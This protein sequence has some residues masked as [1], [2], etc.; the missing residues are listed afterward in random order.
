VN[1]TGGRLLQGDPKTSF[2]G[3][4]TDTRTIKRGE[5]FLALKG[6]HF[7]GHA[8]VHEAVKK[9]AAGAIVQN[10]DLSQ[11]VT[12]TP[13]SVPLIAV[14]ETLRALG[15]TARYWRDRF[16]IPLI[17]ITGSNGKTSTKELIA[18]FL[19]ERSRVLKSPGNYNN[20][21]GLPLTLLGLEPV[22]DVAIVEMGTNRPGE[23]RRLS[24]IAHPTVGI[25]TNIGQAHLEGMGTMDTLIREKGALFRAVEPGGILVVN[26]ND[27]HVS[28][29]AHG[30]M[31]KVIH[32]GVNTDADVVISHVR[33][34]GSQGYSF[35]LS[36]G[37]EE[38]LIDLP[39]VG[40]QFVDN[41]AAAAAVASL[42]EI[43]V[44]YIQSRL[45][46]FIP[47]PMRMEIISIRGANFINDAYNANP[48]SVKKALETL[49]HVEPEGRTFVV[50]GDML[51]LGESSR[52]AHRSVGELMGT[53]NLAGSFLLGHRVTDVAQ[54]A[55]ERGMSRDRIWI[56]R[57]H[58]DIANLLRAHIKA[59]DWILVK[60]SR[61]M[62]MEAVINIFREDV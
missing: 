57:N 2:S 7:D 58:R 29:L 51:E 30:S 18:F 11:A 52:K 35:R 41:V 21:I 15:D 59:G 5:I 47:L 24:E 50:L 42:F 32:Y 17:G 10:G 49:A 45:R 53:L 54:G 62:H 60:G 43:G 46:G 44:K 48:P 3:L 55:V 14:S 23:I 26:K 13:M 36:I 25:I 33:S 12:E 1:A 8:F 28:S 19:E 6:E 16:S 31:A 27:P 4:S 39:F 9:G 40:L 37:S 61:A 56:G 34:H 20:L 38:T 22:H